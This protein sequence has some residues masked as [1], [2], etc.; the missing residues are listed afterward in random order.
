MPEERAESPLEDFPDRCCNFSGHP[1]A[2]RDSPW[3]LPLGYL[4]RRFVHAL[5]FV[6]VL[7][8]IQA[9]DWSRSRRQPHEDSHVASMVSNELWHRLWQWYHA[10]GWTV[11]VRRFSSI[12]RALLEDGLRCGRVHGMEPSCAVGLHLLGAKS[13][14]S[15]PHPQ[16]LLRRTLSVLCSSSL[17]PSLPRPCSSWL[18]C[19]LSAWLLA[20][21]PDTVACVVQELFCNC[22]C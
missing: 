7:C 2:P 18:A 3:S 11:D 10:G 17:W 5:Q 21:W 1:L 14:E 15:A 16:H 6:S 9:H 12:C 4:H 13:V 22:T 19:L 20:A 8:S